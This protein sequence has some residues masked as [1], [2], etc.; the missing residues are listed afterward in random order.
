MKPNELVYHLI[1]AEEITAD[2][3]AKKLGLSGRANI[4]QTIGCKDMKAGNFVRYMDALDYDVIVRNRKSGLE[5]TV[6]NSEEQSS[7]RYD[8]SLGL[9]KIL[10]GD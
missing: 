7:Y 2:E 3:L 4:N 6:D 9:D 10:K 8:F 5:L 1:H